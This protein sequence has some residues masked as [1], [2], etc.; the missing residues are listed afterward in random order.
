M[1]LKRM[2]D[3]VDSVEAFYLGLLC[4]MIG[5]WCILYSW[6]VNYGN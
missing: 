2:H 5:M 1:K 3:S 6:G 4:G